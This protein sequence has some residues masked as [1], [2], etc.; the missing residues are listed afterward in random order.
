MKSTVCIFFIFTLL[1][2]SSCNTSVKK[3]NI[4]SRK[5]SNSMHEP[6]KATT[7]LFYKKHFEV[8]LDEMSNLLDKLISLKKF[9]DFLRALTLNDLD[10]N[11]KTK[12]TEV[13]NTE[14]QNIFSTLKKKFF[15]DI[16]IPLY[17]CN[18]KYETGTLLENGIFISNANQIDLSN[19][20][21]LTNFKFT[22][23][24]EIAHYVHEIST[25]L[26]YSQEEGFSINGYT[27]YRLDKTKSCQDLSRIDRRDE[28][29]IKLWENGHS[30]VDI[31]AAL[32]LDRIGLNNWELLEKS[33]IKSVN[34]YIRVNSLQNEK[35]YYIDQIR[36]RI[37]RIKYYFP[38]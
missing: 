18:W 34:E 23:A 27:S 36:R 33:L 14:I 1:A 30:E 5:P 32:V 24:H 35:D 12:C 28:C 11:W 17:S 31:Y 21:E 19:E 37:S 10:P 3:I 9:P 20:L 29:E 13:K 38:Q 16:E 15:R 4:F 8:D 7:L 22:I 6:G 25:M 26:P 2:Q